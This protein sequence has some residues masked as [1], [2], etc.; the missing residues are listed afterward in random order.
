MVCQFLFASAIRT[1]YGRNIII[2]KPVYEDLYVAG[3]NITINAPIYG[4]LI[5]A[6]GT[7]VINDTVTNDILLAGG[8]A[9][10]NGYVGD[11]IRCAG[12]NLRISKNVNGDVVAA[13]S[14]V[15]IEAGVTIGGLM[16]SGGEIIL[17]GDVQ[18]EVRGM[19]DRFTLNGKITRGIDCRGGTFSMNGSVE[20]QSVVSAH[21]IILGNTAVFNNDLRYWSEQRAV[22][23]ESHMKNG[24]AIY[25]P[26]LH[27]RSE[28][29]Y[30]LGFT[31]LILLV[32]YLGMAL[33]MT[34]VIQYLFAGT[35]KSAAGT[36][37]NHSLKSL[38]L[39]FLFFIGIPVVA[40]ASLITVIGVPIG[41]LMILAYIVLI[42]LATVITSVVAANWLNNVY[43]KN[44]NFWRLS[45]AAFGIFVLLKLIFLT[46]VV[47]GIIL[48]LLVCSSFGAILYNIISMRKSG[49]VTSQPAS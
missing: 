48:L 7:V 26:S 6:G 20:G 12:G 42:L 30:F 8:T 13:G 28:E 43:E 11:D 47:G 25:D 36:V 1:E 49:A 22:D 39:G 4:D 41:I 14:E 9:I 15:I 35:M 29:W 18:G 23:F 38:G 44:W 33:V 32:S 10:F 3:S 46:P 34:L 19:F 40:L 45:F 21:Y 37:Y 17:N 31:S 5:I 24:K 27:I 2:N 16:I